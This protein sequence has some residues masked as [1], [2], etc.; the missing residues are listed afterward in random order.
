MA[1]FIYNV[2][3]E[4]EISKESIK[5]GLHEVIVCL[6]RQMIVNMFVYWIMVS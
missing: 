4:W 1:A 3:I 6:I 5:F 2:N